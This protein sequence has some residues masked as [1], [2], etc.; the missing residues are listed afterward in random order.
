[1]AV[2]VKCEGCDRSDR[3]QSTTWTWLNMGLAVPPCRVKP[4]LVGALRSDSETNPEN[5]EPTTHPPAEARGEVVKDEVGEGLRHGADVWDVVPHHH[6]VEG[7]VR[8]RP[9]RQV[10]HHQAI[11]KRT[12]RQEKLIH[13]HTYT[14]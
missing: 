2:A 13:T 4:H 6:V 3:Q 1:M 14:V 12:R 11:W 10:A 8:S 7:E 9:E 5:K